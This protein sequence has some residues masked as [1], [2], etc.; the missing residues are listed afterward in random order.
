[1]A[2]ILIIASVNLDRVWR[3]NA[4]LR[5]GGRAAYQD[6]EFRFGGGGFN[7]GRALRACGHDVSLLTS[8]AD[9]A[10]GR[11]CRAAL[12]RIGVDTRFIEM[13]PG[14]TVPVEVFLDPSGERTIL[15]RARRGSRYP[16]PPTI[17]ADLIYINAHGLSEAIIAALDRAPRVISQFPLSREH[18]PAQTLIASGSDMPE[19]A[20][21][22]WE[23]ARRIVGPRLDRVVRTRG[24]GPVDLIESDTRTSIEIETAPDIKDTIGAGDYFAA[25]YV[26]G[27]A[28]G[29]TPADSIRQGAAIAARWLS[30]GPERPPADLAR[31]CASAAAIASL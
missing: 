27:V 15:G 21:N 28:R 7:S 11:A 4:P 24:A 3:L 10:A 1:M 13:R 6:V 5:S 29:W 14:E 22:L 20:D 23:E 9:D 18:R 12:E 26:D 25:G 8:L 2:K 30:A 19:S 31:S 17:D 16:D